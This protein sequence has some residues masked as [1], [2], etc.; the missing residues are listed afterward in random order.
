MKQKIL[1]LRPENGTLP[2]IIQKQIMVQKRN[3]L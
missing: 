2:M 3:Y 1:N